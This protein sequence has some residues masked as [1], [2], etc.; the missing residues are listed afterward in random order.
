MSCN[1]DYIDPKDDYSKRFPTDCKDKTPNT[2]HFLNDSNADIQLYSLYQSL[3][4]SVEIKNEKG[5]IIDYETRVNLKD[6]PS[7]KEIGKLL[8]SYKKNKKDG[9]VRYVDMD[10]KTVR[11][12]RDYLL[13]PS[14]N[15]IYCPY[16][17]LSE[18]GT[19]YILPKKENKYALIPQ[20]IISYL[21]AGFSKDA[22]RIYVFLLAMNNWFQYELEQEEKEKQEQLKNLTPEDKA[23]LEQ[24]ELTNIN[25]TEEE[26]DDD[27]DYFTFTLGDLHK[28]I[29]G[30]FTDIKGR[31]DIWNFN[32]ER[33]KTDP[34]YKLG[35]IALAMIALRNGKLID[36]DTRISKKTGHKYYRLKMINTDITTILPPEKIKPT[37]EKTEQNRKTSK[38]TISKHGARSE[39][40]LLKQIDTSSLPPY[41]PA[42]ERTDFEF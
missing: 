20:P 29:G 37:T 14:E 41:P 40:R 4:Y 24:K 23:K 34:K 35:Y 17:I 38:K 42:S 11:K 30:E 7:Q 3:S 10:E 5:E 39:E 31:P 33:A 13:S 36:W 19:Y 6:I 21:L 27:G 26:N 1:L 15:N 18:D 12:H 28:N 16:M 8:G 9:T 25:N 2:K 22:I 32:E